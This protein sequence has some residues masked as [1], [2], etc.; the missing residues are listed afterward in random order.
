MVC[1]ENVSDASCT[2]GGCAGACGVGACGVGACGAGDGCTST[3]D[4]SAE[5]SATKSDKV[6]RKPQFAAPAAPSVDAEPDG[7]G[8]QERESA[9]DV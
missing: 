4:W 6:F 9:V 3:K 2:V 8:M 7:Q 1:E 5:H